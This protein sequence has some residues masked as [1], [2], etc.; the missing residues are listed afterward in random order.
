MKYFLPLTVPGHFSP[1]E[2]ERHGGSASIIVA[3]ARHILTD[4][5]AESEAGKGQRQQTAED[6]LSP[7]HDLVSRSSP[8]STVN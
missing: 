6:P 1:S 8:D 5:E 2:Q 3:G 4:K 7:S